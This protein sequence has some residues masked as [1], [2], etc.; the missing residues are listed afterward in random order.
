MLKKSLLLT[1][2][3]SA[4]CFAAV[5]SQFIAKQYTEALG[6]A[7][8]TSG[9][10]GAINYATSAGC[11]ANSLQ[12]LA[13]NVFQSSE[14]TSKA[15][16]PEETALTVYRAILSREPDSSGFPFWVN[17]LRSGL[18]VTSMIQS[19]M[20]SQEFLDLMPGICSGN[21]YDPIGAAKRPIDIGGGTWSQ[22]QLESC[23]NNN[24]VCS[25]PPRTVVYLNS[26]L[27]IPAG[28]TLETAGRYDRTMYARQAR[29]VRDSPSQ[30]ILILMQPGSTVRNIWVNG[31]RDRFKGYLTNQGSPQANVFPNINYVGGN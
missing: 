16:T 21:G 31:G 8:D 7:P 15:Y 4:Q 9:W 14:Y 5:P 23:I 18:S 28:K 20:S 27:N 3:A 22:A 19:M 11:T 2:L 25:I 1:A 12:A 24:A 6:R 29:I 17:N 26:T 10:Q 13:L 30:G